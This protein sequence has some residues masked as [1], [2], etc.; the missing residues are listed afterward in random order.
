MGESAYRRM[1]AGAGRGISLAIVGA[2]NVASHLAKAFDRAPGVNLVAVVSRSLKSA[3]EAAGCLDKDVVASNDYA[4]LRVLR[5]DVVI[6][7]VADKALAEVV[8]KIGMLDYAPLVLHTSG[9]M[10][11]EM[12]TPVSERT[13]IMYPLQTFS[14][15]AEVDMTSVP[16][17]NEAAVA[18]DL[19]VVDNLASSISRSVHHADEAHR[20]ILH[21]AGVFSSNFPNILLE[22]TADILAHAGYGI[23]VVEPLV[24]AMIDKAFAIGPHAAQ[25]GPARRGD[26]AVI[27]S[28]KAALPPDL[29]NIYAVLTEKI[30]NSHRQ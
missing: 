4:I 13:G 29:S 21:I 15:T 8:E 9:T 27:E 3:R 18:K 28:Q 22:C 12:L 11:K 20:L 23:E 25:T 19:A 26:L 17:F 2:G 1:E 16:F 6:V 10:P 24:R 7:S 30:I 5:P 14:R